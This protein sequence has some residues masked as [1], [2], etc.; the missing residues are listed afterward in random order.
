MTLHVRP[1]QSSALRPKNILKKE[2]KTKQ[3]EKSKG[4]SHACRLSSHPTRAL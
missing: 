3:F 1:H 4:F 2:E